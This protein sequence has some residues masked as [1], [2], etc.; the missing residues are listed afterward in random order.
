MPPVG[1]GEQ[2]A[3]NPCWSRSALPPEGEVGV[4]QRRRG[5]PGQGR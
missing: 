1:N 3:Q 5:V 2:E 4:G